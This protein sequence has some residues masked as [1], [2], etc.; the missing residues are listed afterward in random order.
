MDDLTLDSQIAKARTNALALAIAQS[1]PSSESSTS[2]LTQPCRAQIS[3]LQI[4][5]LLISAAVHDIGHPGH[6]NQFE[7]ATKSDLA[8]LYDNKSVL[9]NFHIATTLRLM[10]SHDCNITAN[11]GSNAKRQMRLDLTHN[12]LSTDMTNFGKRMDLIREKRA[13]GGVTNSYADASYVCWV[14][15]Q[16]ADL[17]NPVRPFE[18]AKAWATLVTEEF[19]SQVDKERELGLPITT[20]MDARDD[21]TMLK[22]EINFGRNV[23]LPLYTAL[24]EQFPLVFG[25]HLIQLRNNLESYYKFQ[26]ASAVVSKAP[27]DYTI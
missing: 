7:I 22:N 24:T 1:D 16:A 5:T 6:N 23:C 20:W 18:V 8:I 25:T 2:V 11:M 19:N 14:L 10:D 21:E 3:P 13:V 17:S 27:I 26:T 9:E 12:I 15:L 4:F